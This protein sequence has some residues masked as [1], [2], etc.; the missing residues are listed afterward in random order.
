MWSSCWGIAEAACALQPLRFCPPLLSGT[1][2]SHTRENA[3]GCFGMTELLVALVTLLILVEP[4][5]AQDKPKI[6]IVPILGHI[7]QVTPVAVSPDG[8][9]VA[10]GSWDNT[11]KL[12]DVATGA[13]IRTFEGHTGTVSSVAF[14][15][16]QKSKGKTRDRQRHRLAPST[17]PH[18][19]KNVGENK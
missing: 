19:R 1:E 2:V 7:A 3:I 15:P 11:I 6:E 5:R 9:R 17:M 16:M 18:V 13:L 8:D 4:V 14:S 12:W 10:S